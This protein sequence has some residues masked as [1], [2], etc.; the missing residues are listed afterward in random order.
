MVLGFC[1][2]LRLDMVK[3]TAVIKGD[4]SAEEF[5]TGMTHPGPGEQKQLCLVRMRRT[6]WDQRNE[7]PVAPAQP[8]MCRVPA[9]VQFVD[10]V[11]CNTRQDHSSLPHS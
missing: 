1:A 2:D 9:S 8:F 4:Q 5:S 7:I 11:A 6:F 3:C 10:C